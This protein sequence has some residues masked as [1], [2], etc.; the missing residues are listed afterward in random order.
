MHL[1]AVQNLAVPVQFPARSFCVS[2]LSIEVSQKIMHLVVIRPCLCDGLPLFSCV[3]RAAQRA[4]RLAEFATGIGGL[5]HSLDRLFEKRDRF[6]GLITYKKY[7][8]EPQVRHP[9]VRRAREFHFQLLGG[10]I[11]FAHSPQEVAGFEMQPRPP[12]LFRDGSAIF[13]QCFRQFSLLLVV[14]SRQLAYG[15]G[16]GRQPLQIGKPMLRQISN[17]V[18]RLKLNFGICPRCERTVNFRQRLRNAAQFHECPGKVKTGPRVLR[19]NRQNA[20]EF[21][22]GF[23]EPALLI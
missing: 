5:G 6:L 14:T 21:R 2:Q 20:P 1:A 7:L 10:C 8:P 17:D 23:C 19:L 12:G 4:V 16:I 18:A 22:L 11:Q 3:G 13:S 15:G 9:V